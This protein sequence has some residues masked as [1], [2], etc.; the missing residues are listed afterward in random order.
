MNEIHYNIGIFG[1]RIFLGLLFFMQGYD[2]VFKLGIKK[3]VQTFRMELQRSR[4]SESVITLA[5]YMTSYIEMVGG[6]M[7]I[8]GFMKYYMLYALG[9]DLIMVSIA[10]G[11]ISP[12]WNTE[13]VF[14][15]IAMLLLLLLVPASW[16]M[17]SIDYLLNISSK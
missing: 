16:D 4:L 3:V 8:L 12:L 9:L 17:F 7:L 5:A 15:R 14:P 2:K 10:M 6:L 1:A 13:L 11:L